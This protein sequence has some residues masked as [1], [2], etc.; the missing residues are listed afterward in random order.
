MPMTQT[1]T[2]EEL[3]NR[4]DRLPQAAIARVAEFVYS[5]EKHEPLV[6]IQ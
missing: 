5:L 4:I 2:K 1:M 3:F 6:E